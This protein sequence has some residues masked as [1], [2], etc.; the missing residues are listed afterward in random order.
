MEM[1]GEEE[2]EEQV[3]DLL[4]VAKFA[5][6]GVQSSVQDD[7]CEI[8]LD[9]IVPYVK[10]PAAAA[11]SESSSSE[12]ESES[13]KEEFHPMRRGEM[14][15]ED[16]DDNHE[17]DEM[18]SNSLYVPY[19]EPTPVVLMDSDVI[20]PDA[21]VITA[22]QT[23]SNLVVA[24]AMDKMV[25]KSHILDSGSVVCLNL[26]RQVVGRIDDVFGPVD[27][28]Y[29]TI[30]CS[31]LRIAELD[32]QV[33]H[34]LGRVENQ[35]QLVNVNQLDRHGID[36][37]EEDGDS[38]DDSDGEHGVTKPIGSRPPVNKPPRLTKP[39]LTKKRL[40]AV[41]PKLILPSIP[42]PPVSTLLPPNWPGQ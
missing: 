32:L 30:V 40:N 9:E 36:A 27:L 4:I 38:N 5:T 20:I 16:E 7:P 41:K 39:R 33:G 25:G 18:L 23:K 37:G 8:D 29:Y 19:S 15:E 21:L 28:P 42:P 14:D 34:R 12:S 24:L 17:N 2:E 6:I 10:P 1:E 31:E 11:A 22:I 3:S 26:G 35:T 13:E